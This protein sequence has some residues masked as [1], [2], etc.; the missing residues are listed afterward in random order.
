MR[1]NEKDQVILY[2]Y[3]NAEDQTKQL[4]GLLTKLNTLPNDGKLS[5]FLL[6]RYSH[7]KPKQLGWF[8]NL[9]LKFSTIHASKGLQADYV[10]LLN[11]ETGLYGFP[12]TIAD[13]PLMELVIPKPESYPH[14]EE[15]R[16]MYVA[17]TRAKKGVF[18]FSNQRKISPFAIEL[19]KINRVKTI[20]L[21]PERHNPC[22]E[23]DTGDVVRKA[24]KFGAF[25][26]CTN[27][28]KCEFTKPVECP[29]C[30]SGKL[31]KRES[32]YGPF[33]SCSTFPKCKH[34]ESI[35]HKKR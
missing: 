15:R 1:D 6:A 12:S 21:I 33:L 18:I 4:K 13:D 34:S 35:D 23:C 19:A 29:K 14:A 9:D 10:I 3:E 27:Y 24:G 28:P 5:V 2:G 31:V 32:K 8:P 26:G 7:L 11:A 22:P 30:S 16:L 25:Y 17:I 20:A